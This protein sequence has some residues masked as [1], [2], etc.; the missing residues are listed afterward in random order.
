[1]IKENGFL[2]S[3]I[4]I[5]FKE[6]GKSKL[7]V[8]SRACDVIPYVLKLCSCD[9]T[10]E[11]CQIVKSY[12]AEAFPFSSED[13][14]VGTTKYLEYMAQLDQVYCL[15][16]HPARYDFAAVSSLTNYTVMFSAMNS[17]GFFSF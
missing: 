16:G 15:I 17:W 1:M 13:L 12:V 5:G 9:Q 11:V 4:Q 14:T 10:K 8:K 3:T 6:P 7:A 2:A